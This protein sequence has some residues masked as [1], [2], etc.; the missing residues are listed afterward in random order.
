MASLEWAPRVIAWQVRQHASRSSPG[1]KPLSPR[2]LAFALYFGEVAAKKK[3]KKKDCWLICQ[4]DDE[5]NTHWHFPWS[6]GKAT[7]VVRQKL[8][9]CYHKIKNRDSLSK[10]FLTSIIFSYAR[11]CSQSLHNWTVDSGGLKRRICSL[12]ITVQATSSSGSLH[13]QLKEYFDS[14]ETNFNDRVQAKT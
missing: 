7:S 3:G 10:L 2:Q 8:L 5:I 9:A 11:R 4:T 12:E 14:T 1:D 6:L 13:D